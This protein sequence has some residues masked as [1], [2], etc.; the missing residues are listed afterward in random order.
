MDVSDSGTLLSLNDEKINLEQ[1]LA[2]VTKM[3]ERYKEVCAL[4]GEGVDQEE[5]TE[6]LS[7]KENEEDE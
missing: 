2:G 7:D 6:V 3:E 5:L 1:Q 4:L